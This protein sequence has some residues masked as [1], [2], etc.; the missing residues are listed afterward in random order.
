MLNLFKRTTPKHEHDWKLVAV[1]DKY[2]T[3]YSDTGEIKY[4]QMRFYKCNCGKRKYS[5]DMPTYYLVHTGMEKAKQNW[6]DAGVIPKDS[7]HPA[8]NTN[9][10]KVDDVER[11]KLDPILQYQKTLEDLV[12]ALGVVINRDFD[13]EAQYPELKK[14]A[15]EYHRQL[16]KYRNFER[17]RENSHEL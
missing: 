17:L 1:N 14:A 2:N 10:V 6:V 15:D 7:Y 8:K 9:Y 5:D 3:T 13:V 16:D 11:E 4:W 12:K